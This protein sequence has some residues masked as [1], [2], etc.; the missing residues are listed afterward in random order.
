[1]RKLHWWLVGHSLALPCGLKSDDAIVSTN[2]KLNCSCCS[3]LSIYAVTL[4]YFMIR[5][6]TFKRANV[7]LYQIISPLTMRLNARVIQIICRKRA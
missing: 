4:R 2:D 3:I 6:L 5:V 1:M 7:L